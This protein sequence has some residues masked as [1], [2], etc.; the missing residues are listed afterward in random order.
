MACKK[1]EL[2][3]AINSFA[4]ARTT[5]DRQ[6]VEFSVQR[7][8]QLVETLEYAPEENISTEEETSDNQPE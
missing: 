3:E 6:L 1:S 8:G 7:V 2:V 4:S 5:G